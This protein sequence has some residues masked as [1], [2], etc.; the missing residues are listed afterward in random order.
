[1]IYRYKPWLVASGAALVLVLIAI[2][3]AVRLVI[4]RPGLDSAAKALILIVP[5]GAMAAFL[6]LGARIRTVVDDET[7]TQH[8]IRR[9]F[10]IPLDDISAV[11]IDEGQGR[12]FLRLH[13]GDRAF[14]VI[15]CQ[16]V[17]PRAM[18]RMPLVLLAV[19][20]DVMD[21]LRAI[22]EAAAGPG[23]SIGEVADGPGAE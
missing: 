16:T 12:F 19:R 22:D 18:L 7:V 8:W 14:E 4:V 1:V 23:A 2:G 21:R 11:Q 9:S 6:V 3:A 17:L 15:P 13:C 10:R 5:L 20:Q